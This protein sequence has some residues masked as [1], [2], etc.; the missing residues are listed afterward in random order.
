MSAVDQ[1]LLPSILDR[2]LDPDS[3]GTQARPWY[4]VKQFL[5]VVRR[6]VEDLLNTRQTSSEHAHRFHHVK[7]VLGF[8]FP[9]M[10]SLDVV[11]PKQREEIGRLIEA[12]ITQYEPRLKDIH[13]TVQEEFDHKQLKVK[14][15]LEGRLALDPAP[16]VMFDTTLELGSGQYSVKGNLG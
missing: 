2:L 13:V 8:G 5:E 3:K 12:V 9:D 1:G 11:T 15:R 16:E 10:N 14:F 7:E 4:T 6:D